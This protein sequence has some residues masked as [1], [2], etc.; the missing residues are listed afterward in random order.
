MGPTSS[1][2]TAKYSQC[3]TL[4]LTFLQIQC[5]TYHTSCI[6]IVLLLWPRGQYRN[7]STSGHLWS[8]FPLGY[9][10]WQAVFGRFNCPSNGFVLLDIFT[11]QQMWLLLIAPLYNTDGSK[12]YISDFAPPPCPKLLLSWFI[13]RGRLW[14]GIAYPPFTV[15]TGCSILNMENLHNVKER[16]ILIMSSNNKRNDHL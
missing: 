7:D 2:P 10:T 16:S 5:I 13:G 12:H 14:S 11:V 3:E 8:G 1:V 4:Q 6:F 9:C 15:E